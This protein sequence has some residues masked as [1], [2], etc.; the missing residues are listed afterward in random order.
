MT[1]EGWN[2]H[3][4]DRNPISRITWLQNLRPIARYSAHAAMNLYLSPQR[5]AACKTKLSTKRHTHLVRSCSGAFY[6]N[7]KAY[8]HSTMSSD[9]R[10]KRVGA[11]RRHER[12]L[13]ADDDGRLTLIAK[14]TRH[15][16]H[17]RKAY[18]GS[19]KVSQSP[20]GS[21][22]RRDTFESIESSRLL[23]TRRSLP[24]RLI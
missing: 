13:P 14:T 20:A 7:T 8:T 10:E 18:P 15:R 11:H 23:T 9:S 6:A 24:A 5:W 1:G 21:D 2:W 22:G 12:P 19:S 17:L 16:P 4:A 3:N